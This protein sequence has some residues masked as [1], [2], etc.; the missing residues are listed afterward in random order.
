L[1]I[2][3][4]GVSL[5]TYNYPALKSILE[6]EY[7]NIASLEDIA[8]MKLIAI[9]QRGVK[10]D[11]I[12]LYFLSRLLGLEQIMDLTKKKYP[13]F[14]RYLASQ[15]LVYFADAEAPQKRETRMIESVEWKD[16]KK[17]LEAEVMRLKKQ[18]S[19]NEE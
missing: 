16:I 11:F 14:N 8:A 19:K 4:V 17:Y 7:L 6:S 3:N 15:A 9:I 2:D 13:G 12:D 1:E 18:W 10:R 5:F